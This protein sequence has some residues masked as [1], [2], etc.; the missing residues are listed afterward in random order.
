[1]ERELREID[2]KIIILFEFLDTPGDEVAPGSNEIR[3][4]FK[5]ERIGHICLLSLAVQTVQVVY[6]VHEV[7]RSKVPKCSTIDS[8]I[9]VG[10]KSKGLSLAKKLPFI[11][12]RKLT[13]RWPVR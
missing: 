9:V 12:D 3:E 4:D 7:Q 13:C 1:M 10:G 5:N 2:F 8:R 11:C 6:V